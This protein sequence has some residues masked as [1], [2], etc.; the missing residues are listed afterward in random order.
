MNCLYTYWSNGLENISCGFG[1]PQF[2]FESA[3]K[4]IT[5]A[6]KQFSNVFIYTDTFGKDILEKNIPETKDVKFVVVDY[7]QY[8]FDKRYWNFPK[9]ITYNMQEKPF[10]HIDFDVFLKDGFAAQLQDADIFTEMIREY[11]YIDNFTK[12]NENKRKPLGLI[13]SGLIGGNNLDIFKENFKIA[14]ENCKP[15]KK[16]I[17]YEDLYSIEEFSFTKLAIRDGLTI[18]EINRDTYIHFQGQYKH[19]RYGEEIKNF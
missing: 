1:F 6:T 14:V 10:M 15:T 9:M 11:D 8:N 5:Q 18:Q 16:K 3:G 7:S 19:S 2:F 13:C 4:S 12:Y 17:T